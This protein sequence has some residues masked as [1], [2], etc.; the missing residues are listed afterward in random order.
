MSERLKA[1]MV[2]NESYYPQQLVDQFPRIA[3]HLESLWDTPE[4]MTLY[5][6]KLLIS[7]RPGRQGFPPGVA[8]ELFALSRVYDDIH[9]VS[10]PTKR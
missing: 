4:A 7:D 8:A 9:L 2:G 5:L 10:P 6:E 3:A 1:L